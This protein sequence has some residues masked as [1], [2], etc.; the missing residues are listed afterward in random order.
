MSGNAG[1]SKI[2]SLIMTIICCGCGSIRV[3]SDPPGAT[4]QRSTVV[5][6]GVSKED[7]QKRPWRSLAKS[8]TNTDRSK[9]DPDYIQYA[10]QTP[11]SISKA[12]QIEAV[13]VIWDD[14]TMSEWQLTQRDARDIIGI[15]KWGSLHFTKS[16]GN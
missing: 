6:T 5:I 7:W 14:D 8:I 3:T 16:K 15:P 13:R 2:L 12:Y 1:I 4:I 10:G 9:I 11:A